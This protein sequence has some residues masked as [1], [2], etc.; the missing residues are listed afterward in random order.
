M[1]L[2]SIRLKKS[3]S[4]YR[5]TPSVKNSSTHVGY[6]NTAYEHGD[7][8]DDTDIECSMRDL[9]LDVT[10]T[11]GR[12]TMNINPEGLKNPEGLEEEL[13]PL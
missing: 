13:T 4:T 7:I 6:Q 2:S 10:S 11:N 8:A 1:I 3:V 5:L 9:R 12:D